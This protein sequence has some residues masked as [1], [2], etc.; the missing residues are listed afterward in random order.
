MAARIVLLA[1][2]LTLIA[3]ASAQER[4]VLAPYRF[5]GPV[6]ELT[7]ADRARADSYRSQLQR[8]QLDLD[9]TDALGRLDPVERRSRLETQTELNRMNDLLRAPEPLPL[10]LPATRALPSL[11]APTVPRS[12]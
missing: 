7:P 6:K 12:P 9:R 11:S 3:A 8:Q 10:R 5:Q 2:L 1:A 4:S